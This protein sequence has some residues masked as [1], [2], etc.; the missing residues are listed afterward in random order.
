MSGPAEPP[1]DDAAIGRLLAPSLAALAE[2]TSL[3]ALRYDL[4]A[5]VPD[6]ASLPA[7][8]LADAA[9]RA[10]RA[11]PAGALTYG[12]AQGY[13]P[14][15]ARIAEGHRGGGLAPDP[16]WVALCSGSAHAIDNV[17]ATFL[18]PGDAAVVGAPTYPGAIRAFRARGARLVAVP[19]DA[20]GLP[21]GALAD[22]LDRRAREGGAPP[23]LLYLVPTYDNPGGGTMPLAR[24]E[25][26]L[27]VAAERR[28]LIVEDDAYA[29]LDLDGPP[30]PSLFA[31]AG[32]RG[33]IHL[34]TASKT[35]AT[36]LRVGWIVAAPA[37]IRRLVFAR[38]DNGASP[39]LHRTVLEYLRAGGHEAHVGRL[40]A[41]YRERRDAAA[42]AVRSA[43]AGRADFDL[44]AGG[45]YLWLRLG[46]GLR[47]DALADA[48]R[49]RGV[50]VTPGPLYYAGGGG[51]RR[52]RLAYPALPPDEL[53]AAIALLGEAAGAPAAA[54][55]A[56]SGAAPRTAA[57]RSRR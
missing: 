40:R 1:W 19:Q 11:D 45:F 4:N 53:R 12:G 41:I 36:G 30:P 50:A 43:L 13:E 35:I 14:L 9:A 8:A 52:V 54:S 10:L 55:A 20:G 47:A 15:R 6:R 26:L 51:E 21:P 18:G 49:A 25:E 16:G 28:L 27:R 5:G 29:G 56:A 57:T 48:A 34:G 32:G 33:V 2:P 24:R 31:L 42:D 3:S 44:P 46:A 38:L 37:L 17:A 7:A 39:L 23:K 22:A